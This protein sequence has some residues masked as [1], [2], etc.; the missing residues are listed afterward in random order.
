LKTKPALRGVELVR[1][2]TEIDQN[3]IESGLTYPFE[4]ASYIPEVTSNERKPGYEL[5]QRRHTLRD[6]VG[7]LIYSNDFRTGFKKGS[8][9]AAATDCPVEK[10]LPRPW[11]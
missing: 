4:I 8:R 11:A 7:I 9:M 10:D 2:N 3:S 5:R 6:R 1:G